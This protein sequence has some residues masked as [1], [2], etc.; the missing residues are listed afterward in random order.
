MVIWVQTLAK[1]VFGREF[2]NS[3][4]LY[5]PDLYRDQSDSFSGREIKRLQLHG[6]FVLN[7]R[8]FR[9]LPTVF[10]RIIP[11]SRSMSIISKH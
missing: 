3:G 10:C 9:N 7:L 4:I 8:T 5:S 11:N 6:N 1:L 2:L